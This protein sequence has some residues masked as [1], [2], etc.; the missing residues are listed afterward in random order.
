[1]RAF[2]VTFVLPLTF[3]LTASAQVKCE[4]AFTVSTQHFDADKSWNHQIFERELDTLGE[5]FITN[6]DLSDKV[7]A[8][9]LMKSDVR[10]SL[11][12]LQALSRMLTDQSPKF[13]KAQRE[14]FKN[15]EDVVGKLDLAMSLHKTGDGLKEQKLIVRFEKQE[16][17]AQA[18]MI[19]A[20]KEAGLWDQPES[21]IAKLRE[22]FAS[23]G[24]WDSGHSEKKALV[25]IIASYTKDLNDAVKEN[26]F[27]NADIE[28]GLHELRR[29]LRWI[30]MQVTT[31]SGIVE[32]K[33]EAG[34][35]RKAE[36]L[37]KDA[38]EKNP[39]MFASK[40][41]KVGDALVDSPILVPRQ[42]LAMITEYVSRIGA[43]K[44]NAEMQIYIGE[45]MKDG[46]A[47][48]KDGVDQKLHD[49]LKSDK[50]DHQAMA[51]A[52]Q[53]ELTETKILKGFAKALE[54]MN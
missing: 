32:L 40:Y 49:L 54:E 21:T 48:D 18:K 25:K 43:S 6:K 24:R 39:K 9:F 8:D 52:I 16:K 28:K 3:A 4:K 13:F 17:E 22:D 12:R 5:F 29:R 42:T 34:L 7:K 46:A 10:Q 26:K 41:M 45:A 31:L 11:F 27:D 1:M 36:V 38:S 53:A 51:R 35:N 30:G 23:K 37:I 14:Y 15:L 19:E 50:V 44:D 33:D 20:M 47:K 2:L